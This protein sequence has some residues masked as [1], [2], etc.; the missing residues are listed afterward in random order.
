M[1]NGNRMQMATQSI[2]I[3][4]PSTLLLLCY[5]LCIVTLITT[6]MYILPHKPQLTGAPCI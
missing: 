1:I 4:P 3:A 5:Y 2:C 6:Y